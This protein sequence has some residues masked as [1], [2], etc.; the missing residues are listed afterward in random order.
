MEDMKLFL[1]NHPRAFLADSKE[2]GWTVY[3]GVTPQE[4]GSSGK[5]QPGN[6]GV[7][8]T[9]AKSA[10]LMEP[11]YAPLADN[12]SV[13]VLG[14]EGQGLKESLKTHA[15]YFVSMR[16]TPRAQA[17]DV[18]VD[19]LNVSVA[20]ALLAAEFMRKPHLEI[21]GESIAGP[22]SENDLGF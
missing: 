12:P 4:A 1:V 2:N 19:S 3:A 8:F 10:A 21:S 9:N 7:T 11:N 22:G 5:Q 18:G 16:A 15:D 20:T 6:G 14:G 17:I 13:L